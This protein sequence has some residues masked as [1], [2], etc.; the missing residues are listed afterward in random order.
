MEGNILPLTDSWGGD[1]NQLAGHTPYFYG[2]R[3]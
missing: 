3:I 2:F 1:F